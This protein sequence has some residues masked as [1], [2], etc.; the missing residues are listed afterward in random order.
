MVV[1]VRELSK[2]GRM[3]RVENVGGSVGV[4]SLIILRVV[5][6]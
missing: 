1:R 5:S 3:R 4:A 6:L 2:V